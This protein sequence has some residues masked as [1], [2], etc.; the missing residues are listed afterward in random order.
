VT[1]PEIDGSPSNERPGSLELEQLH[2]LDAAREEWNELA[3]QTG[4]LF[5]TWEWHS[6][7]WRHFGSAR[8]LLATLCRSSA[9][10]LVAVLPLYLWRG[11]PLRVV[12]LVGHHVGDQLGPICRPSDRRAVSEA[13]TAAL[14]RYEADIFL[15]E[16]LPGDEKWGALLDAKV[17]KRDAS[18]ALRVDGASWDEFLASCSSNLRSQIR[19]RERRLA[20]EHDIRYRLT[21]SRDELQN[22]LDTLFALHKLRWGGQATTFA[23]YEEFHRDFA[24]C[25]L[26]RGWLRLWS[27]EIDGQ[28]RA[29]WYGFRFAGIQSFYQS[30]RDPAWDRS[31]VGSVALMHSIRDAFADG[32]S[33]YRFLRGDEPYK[34]RFATSDRGVE[35]IGIARGLAS[36]A[37]LAAAGVARRSRLLKDVISP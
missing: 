13:L 11:R 27:L 3:E 19:A 22:D 17:L 25:A 34:Y 35:T 37:A 14:S 4:N 16:H 28:P 21:A 7:W 12:R 36:R 5:S 26:D 29:A 1:T 30:G 18:P 9:G 31:S 23:R 20:R 24:A 32:M 15:G 2:E 6:L 33:E 8:T 10:Q